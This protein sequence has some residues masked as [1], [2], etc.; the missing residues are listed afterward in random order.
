M[1]SDQGKSRSKRLTGSLPRYKQALPNDFDQKKRC[2][3]HG[4][5]NKGPKKTRGRYTELPVT[6]SRP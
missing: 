1:K 6:H 4:T 3:E 2:G 5:D